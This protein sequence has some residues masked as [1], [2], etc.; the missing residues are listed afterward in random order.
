MTL[1]IEPKAAYRTKIDGLDGRPDS[2]D[3]ANQEDDASR[4]D[5][6]SVTSNVALQFRKRLHSVKPRM[7]T[8][9]SRH[10]NNI[11]LI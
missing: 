3:P 8:L 7:V 6:S 5:K 1:K 10:G 2:C 4:S 11:L 9:H